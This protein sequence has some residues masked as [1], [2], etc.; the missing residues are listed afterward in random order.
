MLQVIFARGSG[1][2]LNDT[3][4]RSFRTA[5]LD[6][7]NTTNVSTGTYELGSGWPDYAHP[8][9]L[10]PAIAIS[11][12][13][14]SR[15]VGL[16]TKM[17][18][19]ENP[20]YRTSIDRGIFEL[21]EF[22]TETNRKC[23]ETQYIIGGYSQGAH[24]VGD[25]LPYLSYSTRQQ[26]V[27]V[28]L[29]GDPKLHLPEGEGFYAPACRG[30]QYSAWR[31]SVPNCETDNGTLGARKP[32]VPTDFQNK[33]GTWCNEYDWICGS[34]K[35]P[36]YNSGHDEYDRLD[37]PIDQ[38]A[39]EAAQ[40][41]TLALPPHVWH[42]IKSGIILPNG[43]EPTLNVSY[44][45]HSG[46]S[47]LQMFRDTKANILASA[48]TVWS[49]GGRTGMTFY[50]EPSSSHAGS[51]VSPGTG[52]LHIGGPPAELDELF[53][54]SERR[55]F[56]ARLN[57]FGGY[58]HWPTTGRTL[59]KAIIETI[60]NLP[61]QHGA[62]KAMITI[63]DKV[64]LDTQVQYDHIRRLG[65]PGL[66][67][68]YIVKRAIEIDPV[69]MY[70]ITADPLYA[71]DATYFA[72][73]TGGKVVLYDADDSASL[74]RAFETVQSEVIH[75][76]IVVPDQSEYETFN[77]KPIVIGATGSYATSGSI[78]Q[79][80]WDYEGDGVWD[81]TTLTPYTTHIYSSDTTTITHIKATDSE[82]RIGTATINVVSLPAP[83]TPAPLPLIEGI[84]Y[85]VIST[86]K[87]IS[88]VHLMWNSPA[89]PL[90]TLL[91][92]NGIHLGYTNNG[93]NSI[94]IT[95]V[96]RNRATH[97]DL[98]ALDDDHTAGKRNGVVIPALTP[99]N[100][101]KELDDSRAPSRTSSLPQSPITLPSPYLSSYSGD[102]LITSSP[103]LSESSVL[104]GS[105]QKP[106][107]IQPSR[108][109]RQTGSPVYAWIILPA[110]GVIIVTIVAL[111][112]ARKL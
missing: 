50:F 33:V 80:D 58:P 3:M 62:Q 77:E 79:Y 95:D 92:S 72:E 47:H 82:G 17:S 20:A 108:S 22:L 57:Q 104:G 83:S 59:P 39:M 93:Q 65:T 78:V 49:L 31:R 45:W 102:S 34:S 86:D 27:F 48:E 36:T 112:R 109:S 106:S 53:V 6:R 26:I 35:N 51:W 12:D 101:L 100:P 85:E 99:A 29:F 88:T 66:L 16:S 44:V 14:S 21:Y 43:Q 105:I 1:S 13:H 60:D 4:A 23:P 28:A 74:A 111:E 32:Y 76:P 18:N 68:S 91:S 64:N 97:F 70:F 10:Y 9:T 8:D 56:L 90:R 89:A 15:M 61:W 67:R 19:G 40:K 63:A 52:K 73:A 55:H 30:E 87:N 98:Q 24:V 2:V 38:V 11:G 69:N 110:L 41:L 37:G 7:I 96:N 54:G 81:T 71:E 107:S 25:T 75:R 84:R 5:I 42:N 103:L 46:Y 94:I